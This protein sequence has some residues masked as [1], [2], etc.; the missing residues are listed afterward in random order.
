MYAIGIGQGTDVGELASIA[1][2]S[3]KVYYVEDYNSLQSIE[4]K[5]VTATKSSQGPC[6]EPVTTPT[7]IGKN[8]HY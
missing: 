7:P 5:F 4:N 1:D 6:P 2:S 3:E 8:L